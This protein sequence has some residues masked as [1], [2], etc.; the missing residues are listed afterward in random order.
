MQALVEGIGWGLFL[1][2]LVGPI[3]FALLQTG[4]EYG[5]RAGVAV[6][7]GVWL[8]D[9]LYITIMYF[10]FTYIQEITA[11]DGFEFW[12][13]L[14]GGIILL[15]FG[16]G[17]LL[18]PPP[19]INYDHVIDPNK[20]NPYAS[21]FTKGFLV[22]TINPF[23]VFFWLGM[24]GAVSTKETWGKSD[25]VI[26]FSAIIF[27]IVCTDLLK[28]YMAKQIRSKL[29]RSHLQKTRWITGGALVVFG[30]ALILRTWS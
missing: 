9:I 22:N 28:I 19:N 14:V 13:G 25:M 11:L 21:L 29:K 8:S 15:T 23:T 3:V 24:M 1:T 6:G 26:F 4:I 30:I 27:T 20:D 17:S 10:G 7:L 2:I 5:F 12:T 16:I 18:S